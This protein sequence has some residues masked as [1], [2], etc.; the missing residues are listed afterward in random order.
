MRQICGNSSDLASDKRPG[1][2]VKRDLRAEAGLLDA[3]GVGGDCWPP[4]ESQTAP[5]PPIVVEMPTI[6]FTERVQFEARSTETMNKH[7]PIFLRPCRGFFP[8]IKH[9]CTC[10]LHTLLHFY[11]ISA[12]EERSRTR[13]LPQ[14]GHAGLRL[15]PLLFILAKAAL[16]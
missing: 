12:R 8:R 10:F 11:R 9:G 14:K 15:M 5:P 3:P 2:R 6:T 4:L 1:S 16:H 7:A 13:Q